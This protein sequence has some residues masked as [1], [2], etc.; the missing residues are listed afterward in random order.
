MP[1]KGPE[2]ATSIGRRCASIRNGSEPVEDPL[3][4]R[5][6]SDFEFSKSQLAAKRLT[7]MLNMDELVWKD[8]GNPELLTPGHQL[9]KAEYLFERTLPMS[10]K[11]ELKQL[12]ESFAAQAPAPVYGT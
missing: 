7:A 5:L 12:A 9:N 10:L 11:F 8:A 2:W 1:T 4:I 6:R 3:L